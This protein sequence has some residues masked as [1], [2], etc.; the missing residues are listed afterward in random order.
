M[1]QQARIV[2]VDVST[3]E[4][5]VIP[6]VR[7]SSAQGSDEVRIAFSDLAFQLKFTSLA[8]QPVGIREHVRLLSCKRKRTSG[9]WH[10]ETPDECRGSGD[11]KLPRLPDGNCFNV[12]VSYRQVDV[13]SARN[14]CISISEHSKAVG[15]P[16]YLD[17][18]GI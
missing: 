3:D 2:V 15:P 5:S 6:F 12:G 13:E 17:T 8:L 10:Y 4:L 7:V 18:G 1:Q 11:V 9:D 14:I 16:Q